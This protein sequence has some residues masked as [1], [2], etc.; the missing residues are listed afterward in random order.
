MAFDPWTS[1]LDDAVAEQ[2]QR[3]NRGGQFRPVSQWVQARRVERLREAAEGGDGYAVLS[4]IRI[5]VDFRLVA[6]EWL[7]LAFNRHFEKVATCKVRSWDEA[8][9]RP[10]PGKHLRDLR[11]R[12]QL[13]GLV[14]NRITNIRDV[15]SPR[16]AIDESLFERVAAEFK[17]GKTMC[18]ELYYA[19]KAMQVSYRTSAK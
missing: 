4:C 10:Y 8:F 14:F 15:E 1:S 9:G 17:I 3:L 2:R 16:P 19:A 13:Q 11:R 18:A 12:H 6:P 7:A 5:C